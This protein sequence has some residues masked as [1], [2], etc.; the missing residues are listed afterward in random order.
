MAV[1]GYLMLQNYPL[2]LSKCKICDKLPLI[3]HFWEKVV[4]KPVK[5]GM[6][7]A[8]KNKKPCQHFC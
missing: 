1:N 2:P 7:I 3:H 4:T 5:N 6:K 8:K